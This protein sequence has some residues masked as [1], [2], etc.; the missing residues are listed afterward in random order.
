MML[1]WPSYNPSTYS[2]IHDKVY[3]VAT[4]KTRGVR[5]IGIA[6]FQETGIVKNY[7]WLETHNKSYALSFKKTWNIEFINMMTNHK[8]LHLA[9]HAQFKVAL[10]CRTFTNVTQIETHLSNASPKQNMG[11][12]I[13]TESLLQN[14]ASIKTFVS[15]NVTSPFVIV[16]PRLQILS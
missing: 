5:K 15:E 7:R 10:H 14:P 6:T 3:S 8:R 16:I 1:K 13:A 11:G 2:T 4:R 12:N 9:L